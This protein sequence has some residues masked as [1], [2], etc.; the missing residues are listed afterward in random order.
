MIAVIASLILLP[1]VSTSRASAATCGGTLSPAPGSTF[2]QGVT[3]NIELTT[4]CAGSGFWILGEFGGPLVGFG[5][6]TCPAV[7]FCSS[8][9]LTTVNQPATPLP[10]GHYFTFTLNF[11]TG[12]SGGLQ[13]SFS[14]TDFFV[15]PL[16]PIGAIVGVLTSL[17]AFFV[18]RS[19][20]NLHIRAT[21][22][23]NRFNKLIVN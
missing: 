8:T 17:G 10:V 21:R 7:V 5:S 15:T 2:G 3:I 20:S 11:L 6:F 23:G 1:F 4:N 16:F 22:I 12:P 19:R 13:L 14:V 9:I 18:Y